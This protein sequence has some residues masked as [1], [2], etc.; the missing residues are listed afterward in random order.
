MSR[1]KKSPQ[2]SPKLSRAAIVQE[3]LLL[4]D[5]AGMDAL[6]M[7]KLASRM[8]VEAMSLYNHISSKSE[9]LDA[10]HEHLLIQLQ[11]TLASGLASTSQLAWQEVAQ[12]LT[13]GFL[14]LL[15]QHPNAIALFGTRS[16]IS[17]GSLGFVDQCI[18]VLL[19]AGLSAG[20]SLMVFQTLFCFTLGHA[21]FH[22]SHRPAD[23]Y[24]SKALYAKF[25]ALQ[26]VG[27][28]QQYPSHDEFEFGLCAMLVGLEQ[29]LGSD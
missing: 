25:Q 2:G 6:S 19:R 8:G 17:T 10:I 9:L 29:R 5:E 11:Q 21:V 23:S 3:A 16:A 13:R 18:Q 7:R 12:Q 14:T 4:L 26:L 27:S 28:P 22:H 20:E 24:A 1:P 15:R